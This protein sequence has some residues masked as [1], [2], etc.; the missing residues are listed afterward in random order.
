MENK[1]AEEAKQNYDPKVEEPKWQQFWQENKVFKYKYN[2]KKKNFSIDTPPPTVSGKMH[3]GHSFSYAQQDFIA[4]YHRM[5]GDNVYYPFGTD[6]NGLPTERLIEKTKN[7]KAT[8]MERHEFTKLCYDTIKEIKPAFIQDWINLGMS[9]D[10]E[11]SYSTID[12]HCQKTSQYGFIDLYEKGKIFQEETPISWC[13][14]CQTAIAQAEFED[15]E[16]TS[17]FNDIIFKV[18]GKDLIIATTRPELLPACV[19]VFVHPTDKRYKDIVGKK[20]KVPLFNLEV[21]I[22]TD[23]KADPEKGT[24]A[25]MCCTFGDKTDSEW[26]YKHK[27]P[28]RVA[29]TKDGKMNEHAEKYAGMPIKEARKAIIEDMK[30]AGLLIKQQ[31]ITHMVNVH[32]K[33][34]TELEILKTKQWFI[35][36]LENKE[37]L[38]HAADKITWYPAHMKARYTNWVEN[39]NWDWCISRQR[40]FGVPFPLWYCKK[41]GKVML[42]EKKALPVD[43]LRD[44]PTKKCACGSTEFE[45]EKDV[46]DTWATSSL[47]PQ[48]A[49]NWQSKG[50]YDVD[51]KKMYPTT[52]RPQAHDIIRTWAFYTVVRGIYNCDAIPWENIMISGWALDPHGKKMSK[53]KGN[54]VD[55]QPMI[56]KYSA[57]ALRFWAAGSKL[58]DDL[59]FQEKDLVTGKKMVTKLWNASKFS[60]Q[61]L[62]DF[63][64]TNKKVKLEV[65]DRWVLSKLQ[66]VINECTQSFDAYEYAEAKYSAEQFFWNV[67][68]DNYL[69]ICKDRLYNPDSR[70]KEARLSAQ[71][72][73][74]Q[75]LLTTLKLTA[76]IMPFITESIY[77]NYFKDKEGRASIH[78]SPWPVADKKLI[79]EDA[80]KTGEIAVQIIGAV[81]KFKSEQKVSLKKP[82]KLTIEC[83][84]EQ[85]KRIE[86]VLGD[87]KSTNNVTELNFGKGDIATDNSNIKLGILLVEE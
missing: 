76:P 26:W 14:M 3:L 23:E 83:D 56:D 85:K 44:K 70:G 47:S 67:L 34:G 78:I 57:D 7:V 10:F 21:P 41:C 12:N 32:D 5:K 13:T 33:C 35:R 49:T 25:V 39:L 1:P 48:I 64:K 9:C 18:G 6:D 82:I 72:T 2:A 30:T 66:A 52:L 62:V 77:Q 27:L 86:S 51:F 60:M 37:M 8:R 19:A 20:A 38:M 50:N 74:Y 22:L 36:I 40:Y 87:I 61:H 59:P 16:I 17:H 15:L 45:P 81:R 84:A 11:G 53:S 29:I 80:E 46:M 71:H 63:D 24:G 42:A 55:P 65:I 69:E 79:D 28:L 4:R 43:P 31:P 54:V 68:C 73:L 75:L 58:G